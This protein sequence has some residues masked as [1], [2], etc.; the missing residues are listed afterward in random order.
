VKRESYDVRVA[1]RSWI[2][3]LVAGAVFGVYFQVRSH[4]F[5]NF[6]DSAYIT[7]NPHLRDGLSAAGVARDFGSVHHLN[8]HPLTSVSYRVDFELHGLRASGVL[9]TNVALHALAAALL[10]L[11]L[12]RMTGAPGRSAF[13]A[14]VFALHPLHVE[15]VAWASERKDVLSGV[16][17]A[18]TLLAYARYAE[19]PSSRR[20]AVVAA[21]LGL[22]LLS[23]SVLVTAPFVLVL[24]DYWPLGRLRRRDGSALPDAVRLRTAFA[25]K[26]PL[27]GLAAAVG[28]TT[29][30]IQ[31]EAGAAD[32]GDTLSFGVRAANAIHSYGV[33]L[34]D[35]AWPVGLAMFYPH[36]GGDIAAGQVAL[37]GLAITAVTAA[38][39]AKASDR[40]YL[41]VGWLWYLGMLVPM[42]G[43][44]QVGQQA[45]ADRYMYLPLIGLAIAAAWGAHDAVR[46][47]TGRRALGAAGAALV[48][49][50]GVRSWDQVGI[51]RDSRTLFEHALAVSEGNFKAHVGLGDTLQREGLHAEAVVQYDAAIALYPRWLRA[52]LGRAGSLLGM[53]DLEGAEESLRLALD[54]RPDQSAVR[55]DL[56]VL[57]VKIGRVDEGLRELERLI[58]DGEASAD[59]YVFLASRSLAQGRPGEAADHYRVALR[60]AADHP[61]ATNNLAWLLATS[62]DPNVRDPAEAVAH[63]ERAARRDASDPRVLDTLAAAYAAAGRTDDAVRTAADARARVPDGSPTAVE[64]ESRLQLYRSGRA[65]FE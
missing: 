22:G 5:V 40:P 35:T 63:A 4:D 32:F 30:A 1:P 38:A 16:F 23:K 31:R 37:A 9:L 64:I 56:G 49:V 51:W 50:L 24:I 48:L 45:R 6:D 15:S 52:H 29:W 44:I 60:R 21:F 47:R 46:G 3:L 27:F 33:Y 65:L 25:E 55:G 13:V 62:R 58:R 61:T 43:L 7:D 57:L 42:I 20:M 14:A 59:V 36:P 17:F 18:L 28:I 53:G 39:A 54:I 26:W 41:V 8:W 11:A 19:G 2:A 34:V 10:Y 12:A